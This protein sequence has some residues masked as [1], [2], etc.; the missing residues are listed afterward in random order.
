LPLV[1][2]N[3]ESGGTPPASPQTQGIEQRHAHLRVVR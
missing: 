2:T 1:C 3:P